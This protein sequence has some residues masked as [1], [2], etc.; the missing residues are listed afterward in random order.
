MKRINIG[1][2]VIWS[3]LYFLWT[4]FLLWNY[5]T[6]LGAATVESTEPV[7]AGVKNLVMQ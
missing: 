5:P 3:I 1:Q 4:S 7:A 2:F 6:V